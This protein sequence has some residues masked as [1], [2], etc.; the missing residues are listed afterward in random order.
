MNE[1]SRILLDEL[2]SLALM[3]QAS[4]KVVQM[5]LSVQCSHLLTEDQAGHNRPALVWEGQQSIGF[6]SVIGLT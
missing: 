3:E 2:G 5:K 1:K 4:T 6:V